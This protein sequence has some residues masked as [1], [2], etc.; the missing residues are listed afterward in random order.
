MRKFGVKYSEHHPSPRAVRDAFVAVQTAADFDQ[1]LGTWYA[2]AVEWPPVQ[3]RSGH[4]DLI[5]AGAK[6]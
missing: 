3:R 6:L 5:A 4:G 2:P 1:V